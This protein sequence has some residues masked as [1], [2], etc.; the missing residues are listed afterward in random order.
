MKAF[1][2]KFGKEFMESVPTDPGIYQVHDAQG[3]LIY[4]GKA[5]NLRRRLAQY[6]NAKRRKGHSKMRRIVKDASR[7]EFTACPSDRDACLLEARLIQSH[8]P[9]LNVA[10]AFF[11]LYPMIGMRRDA[12]GTYFCYTTQPAEFPE[13]RF[14]GAYRSRQVTREAFHALMELLEYLGHRVPPRKLRSRVRFSSL[15]GFRQLPEAWTAKLDLFWRGESREALEDLVL[16]LVENAGA[17]HKRERVQECFDA[18]KRFWKH[19]ANPLAR[20]RA[21]VG[22]GE[23]P[24][25]QR[26]R[27]IL[28]ISS[29][30]PAEPREAVRPSAPA[31]PDTR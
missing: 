23:Y 12:T 28:F 29:R 7:I 25:P 26:E 31:S 20:A 24:V 4:V 16:S 22:F 8:R 9:R 19:E 30:M 10:G 14:H 17:R 3:M 6:R 1:D 21:R 15:S 18:L 13:F 27:D 2:R 5:K 11:F